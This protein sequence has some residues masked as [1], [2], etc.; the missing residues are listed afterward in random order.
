M[1]NSHEALKIGQNAG[2]ALCFCYGRR[3]TGQKESK[4]PNGKMVA[5]AKRQ[6]C[7]DVGFAL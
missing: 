6:V 2:E 1:R 3:F 5:Y 4:I 7:G